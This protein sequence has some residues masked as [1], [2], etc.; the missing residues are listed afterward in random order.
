MELRTNESGNELRRIHRGADSRTNCCPYNNAAKFR[1]HS[2]PDGG[3]AAS[4][5]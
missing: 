2:T 1:L 4:P 5:E 3:R